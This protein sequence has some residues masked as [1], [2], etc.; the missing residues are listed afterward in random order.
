MQQLYDI[1]YSFQTQF[2]N[3]SIWGTDG[4]LTGT[5]S[6]SQ[7]GLENIGNE[8]VL[9]IF[10]ISRTRTSSPDAVLCPTQDTFLGGGGGYILFK[11]HSQCILS[12]AGS[13]AI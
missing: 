10:Y 11:E 9:N 7:S 8:G 2:F 12:P 6:P 13:F 3:R 4:T 1:K 5:S